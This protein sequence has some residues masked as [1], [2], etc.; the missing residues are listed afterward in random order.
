MKKSV[1]QIFA[2]LLLMTVFQTGFAQVPIDNDPN[3]ATQFVYTGNSND[4]QN[5]VHK[6]NTPAMTIEDADA[7][8]NFANFKDVILDPGFV[9]YHYSARNHTLKVIM[10][11][12]SGLDA[13]ALAANLN[14]N[15]SERFMA[16]NK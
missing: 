16:H 1:S 4:N 7:L 14:E 8:T 10:T 3:A 13:Q 12:N 5:V 15:Y 9:S 11:G 6:Y 2:A